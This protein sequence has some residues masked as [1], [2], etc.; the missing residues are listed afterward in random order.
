LVAASALTLI[1]T[2]LVA[3]PAGAGSST[4]SPAK[5]GPLHLLA[6]Q[7][8]TTNVGVASTG[9]G[10]S[11]VAWKARRS[12]G[13]FQ[14]TAD[15][16]V[17][18]ATWSQPVLVNSVD[19]NAAAV[20]LVAWGDGH[21]SVLWETSTGQDKWT[22]K[23]R[24]VGASGN[25]G[26]ISTLRTTA[27]AYPGYQADINDAGAI[28]LS[29]ENGDHTDRVAVRRA[30]GSWQIPV[31]VPVVS[32]GPSYRFISNPRDMFISDSGHI[33]VVAWGRLP[34][35]AGNAIW[36]ED[37][38]SDGTWRSTRI[39]PT[40]AARLG[41]DWVPESQFASNPDGDFAAVW[42][43]QD[44][45][46][47]QWTTLFA[48]RRA[49]GILGQAQVLGHYRCDYFYRSC[50]DTAVSDSGQA[51]VAWPRSAQDVDIE[52]ARSSATGQLG[53][54]QRVFTVA[55]N[56]AYNGVAVEANAAGDATVN[57]TGGT[58]QVIYQEFVR[59]AA[60][61]PCASAVARQGGPSWL[62]VLHF[63]IGVDGATTATWVSGCSGGEGCRPN[64][65]WARRL[66]AVG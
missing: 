10:M 27:Y 65:V 54:P 61:H 21:V 62:D 28:A 57:F 51:I 1:A 36:L 31:P 3:A 8:V 64:R 41:Y 35:T 19:E 56:H 44:P 23:M 25:L 45:Q 22:I 53:A 48:Y 63:A 58:R 34:G 52:V 16:R 15:V 39:G 17:P 42:P 9:L 46:S 60:G 11:V 66:T 5:W 13:T 2:T 7:P 6:K 26:P 29:W 49:G 33:S 14:A 38:A 50:A 40:N 43:Q 4:S 37:L 47:H 30:N 20:H 32:P 12:D 18:G 24:T 59:C 55:W